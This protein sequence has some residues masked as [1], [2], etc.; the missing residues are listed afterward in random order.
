MFHASTTP[1]ATPYM[2]PLPTGLAELPP[3][4]LMAIV[5]RRV[6][7]GCTLDDFKEAA[8]TCDLSEARLKANI[9]AATRIVMLDGQ[10]NDQP[11]PPLHPWDADPS[12]RV[13]LIKRGGRLVATGLADTAAIVAA[14]ERGGIEVPA[15]V[16]LW[17]DIISEGLD[18]MHRLPRLS[19]LAR[20]ITD[21]DEALAA[22]DQPDNNAMTRQLSHSMHVALDALRDNQ[23]LP[24]QHVLR[25]ADAFADAMEW[26]SFPVP[27]TAK[28]R[29]A[30]DLL[31]K[32]WGL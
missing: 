25:T 4:E 22:Y 11:Q 12:Y 2:P 5:M 19:P 10:R 15:I 7:E 29:T 16:A 9:G 31:R 30:V 13:E 14:L 20:I 17:D 6:G 8:E 27:V 23:Q 28:A 18:Q 1:D 24:R 3:P 26:G 21:L 32:L